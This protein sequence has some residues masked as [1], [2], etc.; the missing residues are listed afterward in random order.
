MPSETF[1]SQKKSGNKKVTFIYIQ[2]FLTITM[3]LFLGSNLQVLPKKIQNSLGESIRTISHPLYKKIFPKP[4]YLST[5]SLLYDTLDKI[6]LVDIFFMAQN[7]FNEVKQAIVSINENSFPEFAY[8]LQNH[9]F[10]RNWTSMVKQAEADTEKD[11]Q[12]FIDSMQQIPFIKDFAILD[13]EKKIIIKT[14]YFDQKKINPKSSVD[15]S[16][17]QD[18]FVFTLFS[19]KKNKKKIFGYIMGSW[20]PTKIPDFPQSISRNRSISLLVLSQDNR[21]ID[22]S[23]T[24]LI[25]SNFFIQKPNGSSFYKGGK[26]SLR[27]IKRD[28]DDY[29]MVAFFPFYGYS[30]YLYR[31]AQYWLGLVFLFSLYLLI[32]YVVNKR[33][34]L[35]SN[36][37]M[38]TEN[39]GFGIKNI[40]EKAHR[41]DQKSQEILKRSDEL[42]DEQNES[43][44]RVNSIIQECSNIFQDKMEHVSQMNKSL[45]AYKTYTNQN[46]FVKNFLIVDKKLSNETEIESD[47]NTIPPII[48]TKTEDEPIELIKEK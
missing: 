42:I 41:L 17:N 44:A 13:S 2:F 30:F 25:P 46:L 26:N 24:F 28:F 4:I 19:K 22:K 31:F 20:R 33:K 34:N 45:L 29:R 12:N 3:I 21:V 36:N 5:N 1:F 39:S 8:Y 16:M 27:S 40:L 6:F 43:K 11:R 32:L 48:L 9:P 35:I 15:L 10:V 7:T 38:I 14:Q 37:L 18:G 23:G 47:N